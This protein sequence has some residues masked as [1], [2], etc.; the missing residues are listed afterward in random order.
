ML[1]LG[2]LLCGKKDEKE[3]VSGSVGGSPVAWV[4]SGVL[5]GEWEVESEAREFEWRFGVGEL[6]LAVG[7]SKGGCYGLE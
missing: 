1:G 3:W 2:L 6:C 7:S 4:D 5:G